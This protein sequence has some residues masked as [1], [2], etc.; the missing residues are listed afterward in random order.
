MQNVPVFLC[1][2]TLNL[3]LS[4]HVD[5]NFVLVERT[6]VIPAVDRLAAWLRLFSFYVP[7]VYLLCT[8]CILST[9][10]LTNEDDHAWSVCPYCKRERH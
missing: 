1:F 6:I 3:A 4:A 2:V 7:I 5:I 8:S 9:L 10:F